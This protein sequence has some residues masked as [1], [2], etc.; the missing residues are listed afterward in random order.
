MLRLIFNTFICLFFGASHAAEVDFTREVAPL[1]SRH[2][3]ECHDSST[4]EGKLDLSG[5]VTAFAGGKH[6]QG[7]IP[8]KP[9][10]S[11]IWK[12]VVEDEMPEDRPPLSDAEKQILRRWIEAGAPWTGGTLTADTV[13]RDPRAAQSWVQRLTLP[14]YIATVKAATGVDIRAE[15]ERLLPQD[16]RADGF[17]N[18]AYN[19]TV[20]LAHVQ[21][22]ARLAGLIAAR[23]DVAAFA[24]RFGQK[25]PLRDSAAW[26]PLIEKSGHWLLRGP[27]DA[28][29]VAAFQRIPLAVKKEGF[30]DKTTLTAVI[31]SMLQSP[32]FLYRIER[33]SA[34]GKPQPP[35][36]HELASRLS[37]MLWGAPP[38][39]ELL[40]AAGA[41]ELATTAQLT[42]QISRMM[43]DPRAIQRSQHFISDWLHLD[44]LPDLSPDSKRFPTWTKELAADMR[45]ETLAFFKD[46]VWQQKR[47]L[48]DLLN[49]QFTHAS[50]R[51]AAHYGLKAAV[52]P[53]SSASTRPLVLYT[54][55]ESS[56]Q[57]VHDSADGK[58][59]LHLTVQE[60]DTVR[61][62][63]GGLH[64]TKAAL[65][66]SEQPPKTLVDAIQKAKALTVEAWLTPA[67]TNQKGPARI[68]TLSSGSS[69]RNFTLGQDRDH[70]VFRLRTTKTNRNGEP[71]LET[72]NGAVTTELSHVV[73]T[74]GPDGR[75]ALYLN[76]QQVAVREL[77]GDFSNWNSGFHL[78]LGNEISGDRPWRGSIH[79]IAIH[80]R[81]FSPED[82]RRAAA[83]LHRYDLAAVPARGGLLTQGS[84]LTLGG[85]NASM[86]E[87]GLFV[88]H[89]LLHSAVGNAPPG[90][91]TT[92]VPSKPG[93]SQRTISEQRLS[94]T[95]CGNCHSKFEPLAFALEKFDGI[96]AHHDE[97]KHGNK[98]REDG[99]IHIP[100]ST[101]PLSFKTIPQFMD[102][103]ARS[104]RVRLSLTRKVTQ[105][106]LG[107]PLLPEDEARVSAIHTHAGK[108]GGTYQ[109][110]LT[111]LLLSEFVSGQPSS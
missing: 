20:D 100:G 28:T 1:L 53:L 83:E 38:D 54:M 22:H 69:E 21:A 72:A 17:S 70:Y 93:L 60:P 19:L 94:Q 49:A 2:C 40:R 56:G 104:D 12:S 101:E 67:D 55:G 89:D 11:A 110:T 58:S 82:I 111:A 64:I 61:W 14:E 75:A 34:D 59:P 36:P 15:A 74:C 76:G 57:Q 107:R 26:Q 4:R 95:A 79:R 31:E 71:A 8:G 51:L 5:K 84:V 96:G 97:D 30:D 66:R 86:V 47:P 78:A 23:M 80:A 43:N 98:L 90:T 92:P 68:L 29:E 13:K 9:E 3:L 103:L 37:Y 85:D 109:A 106:T 44:R 42:A 77:G 105:F 24:I 48:G 18:T 27:L 73:F 87:R 52:T 62:Q 7:I 33:Q 65:I 45:E 41:D 35:T 32:R 81:A 6:G 91:D 102:I 25:L 16:T 108:N 39:E 99:S 50:P 10:Q 46:L 88:L 63:A